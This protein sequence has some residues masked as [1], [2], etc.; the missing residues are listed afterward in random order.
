MFY[1][2]AL[3]SIGLQAETLNVILVFRITNFLKINFLLK[4]SDAL[5]TK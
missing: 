5:L 4:C 3:F 1:S 2:T